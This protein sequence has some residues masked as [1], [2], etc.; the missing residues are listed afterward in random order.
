MKGFFKYVL[1]LLMGLVG[2]AILVMVL[3]KKQPE[4]EE[5]EA[6]E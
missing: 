6:E 4:E 2:A 1:F 5:T 3:G